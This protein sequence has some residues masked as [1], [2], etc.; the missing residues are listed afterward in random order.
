MSSRKWLRVSLT[1]LIGL[2]LLTGGLAGAAPPAGKGKPPKPTI[3][4][5]LI[6]RP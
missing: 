5:H 2:A 6:R 4:R 3:R 1:V